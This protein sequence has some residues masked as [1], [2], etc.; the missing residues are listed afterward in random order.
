MSG[1]TFP[2]PDE[3]ARFAPGGVSEEEQTAY[4]RAVDDP[5]RQDE[6]PGARAQRLRRR[7]RLLAYGT[8]PALLALTSAGWM[9][10]LSL[11]TMAGHRLVDRKS[12]V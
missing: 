4:A 5:K 2:L 11:M 6:D 10:Y 7:R 3:D 9:G 8:V 12:V 1:T